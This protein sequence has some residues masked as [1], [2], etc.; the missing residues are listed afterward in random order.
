M[1]CPK[2]G[3]PM[4][5]VGPDLANAA[6]ECRESRCLGSTWHRDAKC[7]KCGELPKRI[8]SIGSGYTD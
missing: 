6:W 3:N 8:K 1:D 7:D 4:E 5:N 2:C